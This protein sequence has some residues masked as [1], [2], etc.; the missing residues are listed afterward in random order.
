MGNSYRVNVVIIYA[1][2]QINLEVIHGKL[3][4]S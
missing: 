3:L 1:F 4:Q 2:P